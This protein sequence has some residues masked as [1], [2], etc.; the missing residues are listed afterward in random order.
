MK[1]SSEKICHIYEKSTDIPYGD[2]HSYALEDYLGFG[3]VQKA[4][5][6]NREIFLDP[7]NKRYIKNLTYGGYEIAWSVYPVLYH[8]FSLP[9]TEIEQ[10]LELIR[11]YGKVVLHNL[12]PRY[13]YVIRHACF[14]KEVR[15]I[16]RK[17]ILK[18]IHQKVH[19]KN[20][21]MNFCALA[22]GLMAVVV[23]TFS[24][25][26]IAIWT[27][28]MIAGGTDSD[29]RVAEVYR[30]LR[31]RN[32]KFFEFVRLH[33]ISSIFKNIFMRKRLVIYYEPV[34]YI[35]SFIT[36]SRNTAP[37]SAYNSTLLSFDH[38]LRTLEK[39]LPIFQ[40][41]YK[42]LG[43]KSICIWNFSQRKAPLAISAKCSG[44]KTVG[45]KH[46]AGT[47]D[48]D[49]T[50]FMPAYWSEKKLGP[51][52]FGVWSPWWEAYFKKY[53]K[54]IAEDSIKYVGLLRP[55]PDS[56]DL[57]Q[58]YSP[59]K[60][61]TNSKI[62]IL[63]LSEPLTNPAETAPYLAAIAKDSRFSLAIKTRPMIKDPFYEGLIK[64]MPESKSWPKYTGNI[65]E[66]AKEADVLVGAHTTALL[67]ASLMGKIS[68]FLKTEKWGDYFNLS[69]LV[70][71]LNIL[72]NNPDKLAEN[73]ILR[74]QKEPEFKTI[75]K[76]KY[77]Y[78]G[79]N[80]N[81]AEWVAKQLIV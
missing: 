50:E 62:K 32:V 36:P 25:R 16:D 49:I 37:E 11:P 29:F 38:S 57:Q 77:R 27:S 6:I 39:S 47:K 44:I 78:F 67:E 22:L 46:G 43:T 31:K 8:S 80:K 69:D 51:D 76:I 2:V 24:R 71:G 10:L 55:Y 58:Q 35:L 21:L 81:G 75:E 54:I 3:S 63:I 18:K 30:Q 14:G 23:Y 60:N 13:A 42:V 66:D 64:L 12:P 5:E 61:H 56:Q 65:F 15:I 79:E 59:K 19:P 53:S 72:V 7:W 4:A 41:I 34:I 28:D 26:K 20:F 73:I 52:V 74:I 68:I 33:D 9:Y 17:S 48:Y 1:K 70:S 40:R 45:I